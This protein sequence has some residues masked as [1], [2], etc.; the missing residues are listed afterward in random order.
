[1]NDWW[2][3]ILNE[4]HRDQL[5]FNYVIWKTKLSFEYLD[6][7]LCNSKWFDWKKEHGVK[8]KQNVNY[9]NFGGTHDIIGC[10]VIKQE[11]KP[12]TVVHVPHVI[13]R[14]FY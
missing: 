1:M 10:R 7:T 14:I 8:T 4:S 12:T 6:K 5:S 11:S 13:K 9:S 3:Q 2:E